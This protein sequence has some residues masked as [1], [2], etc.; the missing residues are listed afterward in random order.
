[1]SLRRLRGI[2]TSLRGTFTAGSVELLEP[3]LPFP[4]FEPPSLSR[5][6]TSSHL[7]PLS[8]FDDARRRLSCPGPPFFETH[9]SVDLAG[10][11]EPLTP[12]MA[13]GGLPRCS[14]VHHL[15]EPGP[16]AQA[17]AM[18]HRE[19]RPLVCS[20]PPCSWQTALQTTVADEAL[21][22]LKTRYG[23]FCKFGGLVLRTL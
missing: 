20:S 11:F 4:V 14:F 7:S 13:T 6:F 18:A 15:R 12:I 10:E 1:M 21:T 23:S 22:H 9:G 5:C 8:T 2:V 19:C 16:A 17:T 3:S